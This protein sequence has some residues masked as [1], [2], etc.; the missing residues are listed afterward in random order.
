MTHTGSTGRL[1]VIHR[2]LQGATK[3]PQSYDAQKSR[4]G[5][6]LGERRT[7]AKSQFLAIVSVIAIGTLISACGSSSTNQSNNTTAAKETP[8]FHTL[9]KSIQKSKTIVLATNAEYP[10]YQ[11]Y[12]HPGGPMVGFEVDIWN[13]IGKELGVHIKEINTAFNGLIPGVEAGRYQTSMEALGD[14]AG[15]EKQMIFVDTEYGTIGLYALKSTAATHAVT[16]N[17]LSLCGKKT[18]AVTGSDII[19]NIQK[20]DSQYCTAHGKPAIHTEVFPDNSG[21]LEA[22]YSG[23]VP[24]IFSDAAAATQIIKHGPVPTVEIPQNDWPKSYLGAIFNLNEG[25]LARAWLAGLQASIKDGT[26]GK[27]MKNWDLTSVALD[28]PGINLATK[29]PLPTTPSYTP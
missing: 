25:Q 12:A 22:L 20:Y 28:N 16:S 18:A 23:R 5:W 8:L 10:T 21:V 17:P 9:P 29:R 11:Y 26:Y 6:P 13:Q 27:I 24:Y 3:D 2:W 15:R 14:A 19:T 1:S 7:S 4:G